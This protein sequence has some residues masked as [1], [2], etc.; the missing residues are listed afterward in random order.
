[1]PYTDIGQAT[2]TAA[3]V[4][5]AAQVAAAPANPSYV[6][7][8]DTDLNS[9]NPA[10][11]AAGVIAAG[12]SQGIAGSDLSMQALMNEI[13][14]SGTATAAQSQYNTANEG[15][16]LAGIGISNEQNAI[17]EQGAAAQGAE[18]QAL[19]GLTSQQ[20]PES[21]A[22]AATANKNATQQASDSA[23][24]NGTLNTQGTKAATQTQ[25]QN[26]GF[27]VADI[28]RSQAEAAIQNQYS[29]GDIARSEQGLA[30]TAAQN[31]LSVQQ[32]KDQYALGQTNLGISDSASLDQLYTQYLGQQSGAVSGVAAAGAEQGLLTPGSILS[33]GQSGG[34]NLNSLFPSGV[35]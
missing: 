4:P 19:Y 18:T 35:G 17:S 23:A 24:I 22:E 16:G 21:L 12:Q 34:L 10:T 13:G 6:G 20:T 25:Q 7:Q 1:M 26:Y 11:Q 9:T 2:K 8:T 14:L 33:T 15:L 5:S 3:P 32:L 31:G 30:L 29:A 27:Q 28:N